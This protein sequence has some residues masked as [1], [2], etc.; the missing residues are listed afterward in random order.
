MDK[1]NEPEAPLT[2]QNALSVILFSL[3]AY[4][5]V[6]GIMTGL[7]NIS[8]ATLGA[9]TLGFLAGLSLYTLVLLVCL[10]IFASCLNLWRMGQPVTYTLPLKEVQSPPVEKY[11]MLNEDLDLVETS[12]AY[13]ITL[14]RHEFERPAKADKNDPEKASKESS[15]PSPNEGSD[16]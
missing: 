15:A 4:L 2:T 14:A 16:Q 5:G 7:W 9:P 3:G 11:F 13:L 8:V 10:S 12:K 6:A 1:K